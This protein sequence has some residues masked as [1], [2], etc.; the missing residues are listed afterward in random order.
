MICHYYVQNL[1][2]LPSRV[3]KIN[4]CRFKTCEWIMMWLW[5]SS[6]C[7]RNLKSLSEP[8]W[9]ISAGFN[10]LI[11][12]HSVLGFV[13]F[14]Y[15]INNIKGTFSFVLTAGRMTSGDEFSSDDQH[16]TPRLSL[17]AQTC[18]V[19]FCLHRWLTRHP[20][21]TSNH[22][23]SSIAVSDETSHRERKCACVF[24]YRRVFVCICLW[25]MWM[26]V[27]EYLS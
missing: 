7:H 16:L 22:T 2:L 23:D 27:C 18:K 10:I 24:L 19:Y 21:L 9:N 13:V 11:I 8:L 15:V 6:T 14:C 4:N 3:Q 26:Y 25:H 5:P 1:F 12:N 20:D 17:F